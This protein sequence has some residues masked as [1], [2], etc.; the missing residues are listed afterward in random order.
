MQVED[1]LRLKLI[2]NDPGYPPTTKSTAYCAKTLAELRFI[3]VHRMWNHI[4]TDLNY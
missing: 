3:L 2:T 4:N 1:C